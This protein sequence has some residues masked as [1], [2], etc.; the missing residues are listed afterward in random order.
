MSRKSIIL[1]VAVL[2]ALAL[3]AA[4]PI[5]IPGPPTPTEARIEAIVINNGLFYSDTSGEFHNPPYV[6]MVIR[7]TIPLK[8]ADGS[9][10][11][12]LYGQPAYQDTQKVA[13]MRLTPQQ[14]STMMALWE[15]I[16][17]ASYQTLGQNKATLAWSDGNLPP[18]KP[19]APPTP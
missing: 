8:N 9:P 6:E 1:L 10:K 17:T 2:L 11:L 14:A 19:S 16:M 13:T 3:A 18:V 7:G 4:E 15:S 5:T 12:N